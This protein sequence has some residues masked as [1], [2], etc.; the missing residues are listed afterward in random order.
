LIRDIAARRYGEAA[1]QIASD[2]GTEQAW[3]DGLTVMAAVF[4]D[5]EAVALLSAARV[6]YEDKAA[7]VAKTLEGVDPLLLN[8][9]LL[10]VNRGRTSLGPQVQQ[11]FQELLDARRGVAHAVVTTAV[12]IS[13]AKS[14]AI[15]DKLSEISGAEV[16]VETLV[17]D[18]IIG[19]LVAR[20]GDKLIDGSTRSRL[21]SLKRRLEE[22][23]A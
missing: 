13:D 3:S 10:L 7:F 1:F 2:Q 8:L 15:A 18:A 16:V 22:A 21:E 11:A 17:D 23:R 5:P 9:A 12:P 6:S 20:I 19:G 4:S 14:K